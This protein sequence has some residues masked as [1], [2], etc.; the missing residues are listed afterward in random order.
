MAQ[1][2]EKRSKV[3]EKH[4][5]ETIK[6]LSCSL[7]IINNEGYKCAFSGK[8]ITR[9]FWVEKGF[10]ILTIKVLLNP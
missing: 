9:V 8:M 2:S 3:A 1:A 10:H 6:V 7:K 5:K 4:S